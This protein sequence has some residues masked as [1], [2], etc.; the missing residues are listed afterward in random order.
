MLLGYIITLVTV[1]AFALLLAFIYASRKAL[2]EVL[3]EGINRYSV[4]GLVLILVF[5]TVFA[6]LLVH[7]VEQLYFD[8][9]IYQGIALNILHSGNALWCQYGTGYLGTCFVNQLYHDIV[10]Y[11]VFIAIAF[12]IFGS[13]AQTAY[14]LEL[15]VGGLSII[16]V[17]L[18]ASVLTRRREVPVFSALVFSMIPEL[19]IWSRTQAVPDMP[20]M[21]LTVFTAFFFVVLAKRPR[22]GTL[23]MFLMSLVL[24]LYTRTEGLLLLPAFALL[25]FLLG[26]DGIR[27]TLRDKLALLKVGLSEPA[28]LVLVLLFVFMLLPVLYY[29]ITELRAPSYGNSSSQSLFSLA[30]AQQNLPANLQ[31]I[32]AISNTVYPEISSVNLVPLAVAGAAALLFFTSKRNR[33]GVLAFLGVLTV[34]YLLFYPF[35]YAGSYNYGVDVRFVLQTLPFLAVFAGFGIFG[36]GTAIHY[37]ISKKAKRRVNAIK[38]SI[39]AVLV[40]ALVAYPFTVYSPLITIPPGQM[41]QE[42]Y[43]NNAT[44]FFYSNYNAVPSNCLVFSF[45]PD[46]WYQYGRSAAQIGYI[47]GANQSITESFKSYSCYVLDYGYWCTVP[48]YQDTVC[49]NAISAYNLSVLAS[50]P[51]S[52]GSSFAFYRLVNYSP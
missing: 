49:K 4:A 13:N 52:H 46:L 6:L 26:K 27:K 23:A 17:F 29:S 21:M 22:N 34:S 24:V 19:F 2:R 18:L 14:A 35:F 7:P 25:Y 10:G 45:T 44:S 40:V 5:F 28:S 9:N 42:S 50:Q 20:F 1:S 39:Y 36:I 16:G 51:N 43:P 12:A 32:T 3:S 37:L 8:E 31:F 15:L 47:S 33:F 11:D 41:P 38:Y 48:P 30:N